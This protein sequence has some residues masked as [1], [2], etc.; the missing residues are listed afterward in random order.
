MKKEYLLPIIKV[1][2]ETEDRICA[3]NW[4]IL[5]GKL[6]GEADEDIF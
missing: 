3:D 6:E 2:L 4:N 1:R 5:S